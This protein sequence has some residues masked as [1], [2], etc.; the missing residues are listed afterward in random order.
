LIPG[1]GVVGMI[2]GRGK[3]AAMVPAG[4]PKALVDQT[5]PEGMASSTGYLLGQPVSAFRPSRTSVAIAGSRYF[6]RAPPRC[7]DEFEEHR[8]AYPPKR[9]SSSRREIGLTYPAAT[10][11]PPPSPGASPTHATKVDETGHSRNFRL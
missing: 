5:A 4:I 2:G 1:K 9:T 6:P 11:P 3:S 8:P 10:D 7:G